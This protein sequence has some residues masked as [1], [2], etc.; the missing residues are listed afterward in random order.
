MHQR[1]LEMRRRQAAATIREALASI[2]HTLGV[3]FPEV[4]SHRDEKVLEMRRLE[5]WASVCESLI[6]AVAE[7]TSRIGALESTIEDVCAG[8]TP[9]NED[10][11]PASPF[12][13]AKTSGKG[14]KRNAKRTS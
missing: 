5:A 13:A 14:S 10:D 7:V 2:A 8:E 11:T 1:I 12:R 9:Q 6:M 4:Q 3:P